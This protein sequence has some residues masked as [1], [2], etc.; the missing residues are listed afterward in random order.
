MKREIQITKDGSHTISIPQKHLTYHSVYGA[1]QESKHVFINA[2]LKYALSQFSI[3][4]NNA[5]Y[6]FEMGFGTGLNALLTLQMSAKEN[7][8]IKY[9][10][11]ELF[12]LQ[13]D[14]IQPLNYVEQLRDETLAQPFFLLHSC[15]WNEDVMITPL[16]TL[17]KQNTSL[18]N[19]IFNNQFHLIY[20]DAFAPDAQPELWKA[21][22]FEKLYHTLFSGGILVTYCCKGS[23]KR[24]LQSVGF[25]VEKL[26]GPPGKREMIRA[27]K[28]N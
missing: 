13:S 17:H 11:V 10:S 18:L 27:I 1:V 9:T 15:A 2:G 8:S 7:R 4:K 19:T 12:P 22:V 25:R 5:V 21:E 16:F 24:A 6:V 28:E 26:P 3:E 20:Y 14:E 23:V